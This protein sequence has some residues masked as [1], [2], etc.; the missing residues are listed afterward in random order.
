M[1][2]IQHIQALLRA[3]QSDSG[4]RPASKTAQ[5]LAGELGF[6]RIVGKQW[7]I[8][9]SD[10]ERIRTYLQNVEGI[11]PATP[12]DAWSERTR[13]EA[14]KLGRNEKLAGRRPR[15]DRLA[16]RGPSGLRFG[17]T[18]ASFPDQAF[19]DIPLA[20]ADCLRFDAVVVV[21]NFEAFIHYEEAAIE[22]PFP[23]PL[24]IF[25]GDSVNTTDTMLKFL[26]TS[27]AP[28]IAWPDLDAA[29]LLNASS[30]PRLAGI[31]G[32]ENPQECLSLLGRDDLYLSQLRELDA[33]HLR[34]KSITLENS[35]RKCRKGLDQERMISAA[36]S[37]ILWTI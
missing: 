25:R 3:C 11:D 19:L 37:L 23:Q 30:L 16:L 33:L 28:V 31:I 13:I 29:G 22:L 8:S 9:D 36:I 32:P 35:I 2:P 7:H 4:R 34:G 14:G 27:Q 17:E 15:E 26:N 18:L 24:I 1:L 6:G 21:E 10:R 12:P 20:K 5:A